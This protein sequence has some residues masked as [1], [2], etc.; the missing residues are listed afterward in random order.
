MINLHDHTLAMQRFLESTAQYLF[1]KFDTDLTDVTLVFPNRRAGVFFTAYLQQQFQKPAFGPKITTINELMLS[2]SDLVIPDKLLL[3]AE[4][5]DIFR[6]ETGSHET[7]DEFYYWGEIMLAD[8]DDAD[9][10]LTN[11]KDLFSNVT[12]IKEIENQFEYLT[13][14]QKEM[15]RQFW[16]SLSSDLKPNN[17]TPVWEK[18]YP[19]YA[20]FRTLL[21]EK[22]LGYTGMVIREGVEYLS[23][24]VEK[25]GM[26]HFCFIGLNALNAC[27]VHLM[28]HLKN[29]QR[30]DFFWDYDLFYLDNPMNDAGMFLRENRQQFP[31]PKGF[32]IE[33]DHFSREKRVEI[34]AVAGSVAQAQLIPEF[35][36]NK[37]SSEAPRF[38]DTAIV[39]ADESL[40]VPVLETIPPS[41]GRINVTMG[42]P[43]KNSPVMSLLQL[44][45]QML[46][47]TRVTPG[48]DPVIYQRLVTEILSHQIPKGFAPEA[49]NSFL[50]T[51]TTSNG[52]Y[53]NSR[54][55]NL[56]PL[57]EQMFNLPQSVLEYPNYFKRIL[58]LIHDHYL[59]REG[60]AI[61]HSITAAIF[62]SVERLE[63]VMLK[64]MP[65]RDFSITPTIFF[66]LLQQYTGAI[67]VPF[68]G[69]PLS[70]IQVMGIL[71]TRCLDFRRLIIVGL[72][73]DI[74]PRT[75]MAPSMIPYSL[76][77]AFGLP[78][79][80]DQDAMYAYYF[81]R[82]IQ[83][84]TNVTATWNNIREGVSGGEL[85]RYGHQLMLLSPNK[86]VTKNFEL[87]FFSQPPGQIKVPGS[88]EISDKLLNR[89]SAQRPL[90][91]SAIVAWASCSFKFYLSYVLGLREQNEVS[92]EIDQ[93]IFGNLFHKAME[94]LYSPY[95]GQQIARQEFDR[96]IS[97]N[98]HL[99][100]ILRIAFATE[101]FKLPVDEAKN[102]TLSGKA[103]LIF[104]TL[105]KYL[106]NLLEEDKQT[107]PLTI[108]ALEGDHSTPLE[109]DI[110]GK[111]ETV[112]VGG[113][114]D[115]IDETGGLVRVVDYKTGSLEKSKLNAKN[116]KL[117]SLPEKNLRKEMIQSLTY[118]YVLHAN[119]FTALPIE[120]RVYAIQK[121]ART[122]FTAVISLDGNPVSI[123]QNANEWKA[124]LSWAIAQIYDRNSSFEQTPYTDRCAYCQFKT[125]CRRH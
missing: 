8:F 58:Q 88:A 32:E 108:Y 66:R 20:K 23:E 70:G 91:P 103:L 105:K 76:R 28:R 85:S 99:D 114:I 83:R 73:E 71:E 97:N 48:E 60:N 27:E 19:I 7:F 67:S 16:G 33:G 102:I 121:L 13:A 3:I 107:A 34:I 43:V 113:K 65:N 52:S 123:G 10:Y 35:L 82:L 62:Q 26:G 53:I 40:L 124:E 55:L 41:E 125:L 80:D 118:G 115:R 46:R 5:Y 81:Y 69:E 64:S 101:Y 110:N 2:L 94:L 56:T 98:L 87:P 122:D 61:T 18:F 116:L 117:L 104:Y 45:G 38:D 49:T 54:Q 42:Y 11:A 78:G 74:W 90:S 6:Q 1:Q 57:H 109:V 89:N 36:A 39:L 29:D 47:N 100:Q 17:F 112:F 15:L 25:L 119:R 51:L 21:L 84:S 77:K 68:E 95:L 93:R 92:E 79:I 106:I 30:A 31:E 63:S 12:E 86:V 14:A 4:L 111:I 59:Q 120:S 37:S 75:S 50:Q 24:R 96:L 9:K 72:N 44:L 22:G